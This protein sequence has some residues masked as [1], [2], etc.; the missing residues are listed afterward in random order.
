MHATIGFTIHTESFCFSKFLRFHTFLNQYQACLYLFECISH[1]DSKYSHKIPE[2]WIFWNFWDIL[3]LSSAHAIRVKSIKAQV[4]WFLLR[5]VTD[6]N[7][8]SNGVYIKCFVIRVLLIQAIKSVCSIHWSN[9][10]IISNNGFW[11][12]VPIMYE[13]RVMISLR[14][15]WFMGFY[16][17]Y[18]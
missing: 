14:P 3:N 7:P 13:Y 15:G 5:K 6:I 10:F 8:G 18:M 12:Q 16:S 2:F 17:T 11:W 4:Q 1:G 9:L